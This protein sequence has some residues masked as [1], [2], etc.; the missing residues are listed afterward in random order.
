M[1]FRLTLLCWSKRWG[2]FE[3][4]VELA[5]EVADQAASDLA[6][7]LA[8]SPSPLG[9]AA[10]GRVVSQPG[11]DDE[12]QRL[13]E[14]AVPEAIQ[15][16]WHGLAAGGGD[17]CDSAQHGEGGVASAAAGVG[18][19]TQHGCGHDRANPTGSAG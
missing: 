7:G 9:V 1:S 2:G 13:V 11:Q 5:G 12:V 8:L 16:D 3:E 17:G 18:P 6:V 19:G 15:P 4:S 14:L 10:G